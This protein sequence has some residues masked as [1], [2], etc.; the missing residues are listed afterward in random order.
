MV[1]ESIVM[2]H[3]MMESVVMGHQMMESAVVG[4]QESGLDGLKEGR[5]Y[6]QC[7]RALPVK[8]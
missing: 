3:Q 1:M 8:Q 4:H 6:E 7:L 2:G 5:K